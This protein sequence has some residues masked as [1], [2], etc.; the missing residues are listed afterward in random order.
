MRTRI[1]ARFCSST[2]ARIA[3]KWPSL[4]GPVDN[5]LHDRAGNPFTPRAPDAYEVGHRG[6]SLSKMTTLIR[7]FMQVDVAQR[8]TVQLDNPVIVVLVSEDL[9]DPA[10]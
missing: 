8:L 7:D 2:L 10:L 6:G 3:S 5:S 4:K 9:T 1:E